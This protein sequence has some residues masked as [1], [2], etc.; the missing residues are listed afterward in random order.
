[1]DVTSYQGVLFIF[2]MVMFLCGFVLAIMIPFKYVSAK[3]LRTQQTE[4]VFGE[5]QEE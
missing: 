5:V 4:G 1:M 2:C 3:A